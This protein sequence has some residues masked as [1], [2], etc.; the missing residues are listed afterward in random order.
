MT[1]SR[2]PIAAR[3]L[4]QLFGVGLFAFLCV[5]TMGAQAASPHAGFYTG[6]LY[7][8]ISG[9]I[10]VPE[11]AIGAAI[12]TVDSDGNITGNFPGTVDG[13]G[14]ITWGANATGFTTGLISGGVLAATNSV[15]N[16]AAITTHRIAAN[17][18]SGGF[19]GGGT[20]AQSLNW[21]VPTPT[22]ANMRGVTY[23]AGK[24]LAVGPAGCA[25]ISADGTNWL[26]VNTVTTKQ[27]NS[28]AFGNNIFVAVGEGATVISSP[29]GLTWTAR[30]MAS[31]PLQ[32]FV[33][34]AFGNGTFVAVNLVNELFTS[35]DGIAWTK[36][37][38]PPAG[39]FWNNLK[40]VGGMFVL[41]GQSSTSGYIA[42]SADGMTWNAGKSLASTSGILDVTFGNGKWVGVSS[43][44]YFTWVNAD[45][46][47]AAAGTFSGLGDAVGFI[48]GVFVSDNCYVS[49]NGTAWSR[50]T[51]PVVD[52]NDMVTAN[53]LLVAAGSVM[54][55][56][57]DGRLW[58]VHSRTVQQPDVNNL[59]FSGQP[60]SGHV[61]DEIQ[62]YDFNPVLQ[63]QS[64]GVG[65][66][67]PNPAQPASLVSPTTNTLRD[68]HS[69]SSSGGIAVGENGTIV[70]YSNGQNAWTNVP[71]GT[72]V[73]L[74]SI[75][76]SAD[77]NVVVV[78]GGGTILRS[79]NNG[80]SWSAV[81]SGTTENLNRVT[82]TTGAGFNYFV[83]VGDNGVIR[84][85]TNGTTW[86]ALTSGTT[87]RLVSI[88]Q[89][90]A[91]IHLVAMAEDS[92]VLLS[93]NH[94]TNWTS[95]AVNLPRPITYGTS[96]TGYAQDGL[97]MTT[98][99]GTNWTYTF[100]SVS[101]ISGLGY[102]NGR[103][104]ALSGVNRM[105]SPDLVNWSI[106]TTPHSHSGVAFGNGLLVSIGAGDF[107]YSNGFVSVSM[108]GSRWLSQTTP[109][110]VNLSS[111]AYGQGKF[112][113]VGFNGT[114]LSSTNGVNWVD[115][116]TGSTTVQLNSVTY[117]NG[118]FVAV[119]TSGAGRYST[120][121]ENWI[122]S[123]TG[124]TLKSVTFAKG[125]FVAVG[126]N[127]AIRTSV[128]GTNWTSRSSSPSTT[129]FLN[130]V[131]YAGD[132]FVAVGGLAGSGEGALV[133]HSQNG[134]NWTL[135]VSNIPSSLR[136]AVAAA[137]QYV[138]ASDGAGVIV[139]A[140]YQSAP[141]PTITG[142]PSPA[143][144][145]VNAGATVSY[146]VTATGTNLQY[147]WLNSGSPMSDGPG[148][149]GSGT[150]TLTLTGVDV[151]DASVYHVSVWN[152]NGSVL[153]Q[154]VS[155]SVTGPP[156]IV[157]HPA[158]VTVN[159]L[160]NAQFIVGAAGPA[161]FTYQW[162]FNGQPI[163]DGGKFSGAMTSQLV[164]S[165]AVGT[166]EGIFDVI[167]S[168]AFG[169]SAPSSPAQ[170]LVNRAPTITQ[171]P[172]A[173]AV[174]Q[175]QTLSLTVVADGTQPLTYLWKRDGTNL[176]NGGRISGA[177]TATLTIQN[178]QLA[179]A[180]GNSGYSVAVTNAFA[181]GVV[182][183]IAYPSVIA[184]GAL[185]PDFVTAL[186]GTVSDIAPAANG[187]FLLAGDLSASIGGFF[188][189]DAARVRAD[190][191]VLTNFSS[192]G[193]GGSAAVT[194]VREMLNGQA[195][196]GGFFSTWIPGNRLWLVRLNTNGS[197]DTNFTHTVGS[198]VKR[199]LRLA[200]G[201]LLVASGSS[202]FNTGNVYRYNADGTAD[203]T[204][205]NVTLSGQLFDMA[206]QSD[207]KIIVSGAFGLRRINADG[208]GQAAFGA[209][210]ANI[211]TVHV[212]PDDK[213]YFSDNNG[214]ALT[215]FNADG[216]AD[217]TFS[218][219]MN[220]HVYGM[221]FLS[222]GRMAIVGSFNTVHGTNMPKIALIESN[223]V[224]TAGFTSTYA[225][226]VGN[227][228]YAIR[229]LGDGTALVGGNIQVTQPGTQRGLQRVQLDP[230]VPTP[231]TITQAPQSIARAVGASASFTV[232]ASGFGGPFSYVWKKG[233][234]ALVNG[235]AVSG[236][237]TTTLTIGN[238]QTNNAGFYTV[239]VSGLNGTTVSGAAGLSIHTPPPVGIEL[240]LNTAF[241]ANV[242]L[243]RHTVLRNTEF[244]YSTNL[245]FAGGVVQP[246]GKVVVVG[247]FEYSAP[248]GGTNY[249]II[250]LNA[251]G[252]LDS[253]FTP[254]RLE[255]LRASAYFSAAR[256]TDVALLSDGRIA[257]VGE[258]SRVG[259]VTNARV[260]L[261]NANG[262]HDTSFTPDAALNNLFS[263][264]VD[265]QDRLVVGGY[266]PALAVGSGAIHKHVSRLLTTGAYDTSFN[267]GSLAIEETGSGTLLIQPDGKI[268]VF[269]Y[270][271]GY[272]DSTVMRLLTNGT[273]DGTFFTA[274][275]SG[276]RVNDLQFAPNGG[277]LVP[278]RYPTI[279][280]QPRRGMA[281]LLAHGPLDTTF[282]N[283]ATNNVLQPEFTSAFGFADGTL[284]LAGSFTNIGGATIRNLALVNGDGTFQNSPLLGTGLDANA[285]LA[286]ANDARSAVFVCGAH[287]NL[288][289]VS[290]P[291]IFRMNAAPA[292]GTTL[293]LQILAL[294]PSQSV[295]V[296]ASH[297]LS[298]AATGSGSLS[299]QWRK[300]GVNLPGES[301]PQ[302]FL[303]NVQLPQTGGYTVVITDNA[304][305]ITS[306]VV[307]LTLAGPSPTFADWKADKGLPVGQDG[308]GDDPDGDGMSNVVEFAFGT[309]P[310]Q[311]QSRALPANR[312]HSEGGLEY[313]AV[314]FIRR[315]SLN[316]ANIVVEAFNGIPF[317]APAG[318]T[319]V[320]VP[321]D[322]GDGT[323]RVTIRGQTPLRDTQRYFFRTRVQ[324]P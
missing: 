232:Q 201:K 92:T 58:S 179:D 7:S 97:R 166:N 239:E 184:P 86:T 105:T 154:P 222:G 193:S 74:R 267:T 118:A 57:P 314:T 260:V 291:R 47:D 55:S 1:P 18:S 44:R 286:F 61:W 125:L 309:H 298:V 150:A 76:A 12:F 109:T 297:L 101:G 285:Q 261:L 106:A 161:P 188:T 209:A 152:E 264:A 238:V 115:R 111:V 206:L 167:V 134:T 165:N 293:P 17:I 230:A 156:I 9:T 3:S 123:A 276:S 157:T 317:G 82:Y 5:M 144:Q 185:R 233:G 169:A 37:T 108:D 288:N 190:G 66:V 168:N 170:L 67:I 245:V 204:F 85:S 158:S 182:S 213:V 113:A 248:G 127:G 21:R 19:G 301:G 60:V 39:Q 124:A 151:L 265:T 78:G 54:M 273:T 304:N 43:S 274:G 34:V 91:T 237:G 316:G 277:I 99:D 137:G 263:V 219:P 191:T 145:S 96:G 114:I 79:V 22:G 287:T 250:R 90:S 153:S 311:S 112:V 38:N 6:Y 59:N 71:S 10:T 75:A 178:A 246:D 214:T 262:T 89:R 140:P 174:I 249:S 107:T 83:A 322:L 104:V 93:H 48:N 251:D 177:N 289:G 42:T 51:Y 146:T 87:K 141:A 30:S 36:L 195:F 70:R 228:L 315:K 258:V 28:V 194:S 207:G 254:P 129:E 302:V 283:T 271:A 119:G 25:A 68:A 197:T 26:A 280:G 162:R 98:T 275:F 50:S 221:A 281:R 11:S 4:S 241:N 63:N 296:G 16:G 192:S 240:T 181:P 180:P 226:T 139:S 175:G 131:Q 244:I 312:R 198:P 319:Q 173:Q 149:S 215:R 269:A 52:I 223:G 133:L 212:G 128:N 110:R 33:G 300:D 160:Q 72:T 268:L 236:Q 290:V 116:T 80:Q 270:T 143:G 69:F 24:F 279:S 32:N 126:D 307:N 65:G 35:T 202:G 136:T 29:D 147:R 229:P 45:A 217:G 102:G 324:V 303:S 46:S 295:P 117:G 148:V 255:F 321:E 266:R 320:G 142:Q 84:K 176:A 323:E 121:G 56:T 27:L 294:S 199:I 242:P 135:E 208:T 53:N 172:V 40:Y 189:S 2:S 64:F 41:V 77:A 299:Y 100:P 171:Q 8:S 31:S 138:A 234:V 155:L 218:A 225:P 49:T 210:G 220:G 187:D 130:A 62:Y 122:S 23:G 200:D 278:G 282:T 205:T 203:G 94:G 227:I 186:S 305:S 15:N 252:T 284:L 132:R 313:P 256:V 103:Y 257:L 247:T 224:L 95:I 183:S 159:N 231:P 13:A 120:D 88:A 163:V 318:T 73:S 308:P 292:G 81:A 14:V 259:G 211:P 253:G 272:A 164:V 310:M 306:S 235:G 196:V 243:V 216:T 20:V